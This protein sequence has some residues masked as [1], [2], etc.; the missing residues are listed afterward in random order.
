MHQ[1]PAIQ[2]GLFGHAKDGLRVA[3]VLEELGIWSE[4][5]AAHVGPQAVGA[6]YQVEPLRCGVFE[7]DLYAAVLLVDGGDGV[8]EA[9]SGV[10]AGC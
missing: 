3:L 1:L 2:V 6:Y 8:I 7:G 4:G 5:Q 10:V 9:V